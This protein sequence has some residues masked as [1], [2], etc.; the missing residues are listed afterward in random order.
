MP[1]DITK[2]HI[3]VGHTFWGRG[4]AEISAMWLLQTLLRNYNVDVVTRGGWDIDE[5]NHVSGTSIPKDAIKVRYA[6]FSK[7]IYGGALWV[8]FYKRFCRSIANQYDLCVTASRVID[9]GVPAVHFLTDVTW[10]NS[11]QLKFNSEELHSR[12]GAVRSIYWKLESIIAGSSWRNPAQFDVIVANSEWTAANSSPHCGLNPVVICPPVPGKYDNMLPWEERENSFVCLGRISVEKQIDQVIYILDAVRET[13]RDIK[14]HIVGQFDTSSYSNHILDLH[15]TRAD[16]IIL[17][18]GLYGAEKEALLGRCRY[19]ISSCTHEAFGIATAEMLKAGMIPF[20]PMEGAQ[21]EI[22]NDISLTYTSVAD[23]VIKVNSLLASNEEQIT[24]YHCFLQASSRF[25]IEKYQDDVVQFFNNLLEN[26]K[27]V[28]QTKL[29]L[30]RRIY[31]VALLFS[32]SGLSKMFYWLN[33][34][35]KRILSYHNVIPDEYYNDNLVDCE[36]R[37]ASLLRFQLEYLSTRFKLGC[38][39]C[40]YDELTITFDDGYLNQFSVAHRI[41]SD[42]NIRAYFF[43]TTCLL[44]DTGYP[45][46]IDE[47]LLWISL[48]PY[49]CYC[50]SPMGE[51]PQLV[52][53]IKSHEDRKRCWIDQLY[54]FIL[55]DKNNM[56]NLRRLFDVC[57]PYSMLKQMIDPYY[58]K[59]RFT[60]IH[61]DQLLVMSAFGH[62]IGPHSKTHPILSLLSTE[63]LTRELSSVYSPS[64]SDLFNV[65]ML[66]YPF[67]G[68]SEVSNREISLA[69]KLEYDFAFANVNY[70]LVNDTNYNNYFVPRFTLPNTNSIVILDFFLSGAKYFIQHLR[71]FPKWEN[72]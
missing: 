12:R 4:G 2:K 21:R 67:G 55:S 37:S 28:N 64:T 53:N 34:S 16:W 19:G 68:A 47:L 27:T 38:N 31:L 22:V 40:N 33:R 13:N 59:L 26:S 46:V 42:L 9:W 71:L 41:L 56:V 62:C 3:L 23:A 8:G 43:I 14:L 5:L 51:Y 36:S 11:L 49:G 17:H 32:I 29:Y 60:P 30:S 72:L 25:N 61:R 1:S 66:A 7:N 69:K 48:V 6:P 54:P 70:P 52:I 35:R 58:Y 39:I 50:I 18:G 44:E 24:K 65:K 10:N 63:E 20:I 45:L 57:Y 15:K